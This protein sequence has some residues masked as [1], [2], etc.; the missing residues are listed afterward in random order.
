[1]GDASTSIESKPTGT[2]QTMVEAI[3][4]TLHDEMARDERMIML[5]QD[6]GKNGGVFRAT[7]GLQATFGSNRVV[8]TPL[9]E[10]VIIGTS[11]GLAAAGMVPVPEIQFSP[12]AWQAWH[13][14]AGQVSRF[15]QRSQGRH[16]MPI[17]IRMPFGGGVRAPEL[18]QE[19]IVS[20]LANIPGLKIVCPA[21]AADARGL[22]ASSIRDLDPVVFLEPL[23]GYRMI[24][25]IVPDGEHLVPLGVA[26]LVTPGTDIVVITW[27]AQVEVARKAAAAV[28]AET[29]ASVA[30][31]DLRCLVPLDVAA[32]RAIVEQCGRAVVVDEAPLTAGFAAEVVATIQE[33][34][35]YS[36]EAPVVRVTGYDTPYPTGLLE[37]GFVPDVD[38]VARAIGRTLGTR[39]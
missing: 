17:T 9:A 25:G 11:V 30:V 3:R 20:Q 18:H 10:A 14:I 4:A 37:D 16:A 39:P 2:T 12:F 19:S 38:R 5:G 1:M 36:L 28:Q 22:L 6:I 13:Q 26:N 23:R 8:D 32:I 7:D 21:S 35:F 34:C 15:R 27:S 24:K 29:G 33:E 31:L